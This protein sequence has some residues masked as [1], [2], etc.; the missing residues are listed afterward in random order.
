MTCG[1]TLRITH[2]AL[3]LDLLAQID[4]LL[5]PSHSLNIVI[6]VSDQLS[7]GQSEERGRALD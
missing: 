3:E 1:T 2:F 4:Q 6:A 7:V 5:C